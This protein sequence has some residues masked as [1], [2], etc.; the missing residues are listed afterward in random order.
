LEDL[1]AVQDGGLVLV[2]DGDESVRRSTADILRFGGYRVSEAAGP[3]EAL[4]LLAD[5]GVGIMLLDIGL[6]NGNLTRVLDQVE[7]P[8]PVILLSG[9]RD[10]AVADPRVAVLLDKPTPPQR[11][12]EE[13]ATHIRESD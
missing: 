10:V 1:A 12:L 6:S 13:V 3:D 2:V 11:L 5:G 7:S 4:D 8:P 9:S